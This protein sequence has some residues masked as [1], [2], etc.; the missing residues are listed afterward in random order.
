MKVHYHAS[1]EHIIL[2]GVSAILFINIVGLGAAM[3]AKRDGVIG[4]AG[5]AIGSVV[6]FGR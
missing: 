2:Y 3:L 1:I 4:A 5:K 6:P